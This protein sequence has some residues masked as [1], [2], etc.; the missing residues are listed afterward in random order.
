MILLGFFLENVKAIV[1]GL[2]DHFEWAWDARNKL[3]HSKPYPS[4]FVRK[5]DRLFYR[6]ENHTVT[7]LPGYLFAYLRVR[8]TPISQRPL[9][10]REYDAT[11]RNACAAQGSN[12]AVSQRSGPCISASII[13]HGI[14]IGANLGPCTL[15]VQGAI[16]ARIIE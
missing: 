5:D 10:M 15:F 7:R 12:L 14:D 16:T 8:D 11:A 4:L 1:E 2:V 6:N 13:I 3:L 9:W